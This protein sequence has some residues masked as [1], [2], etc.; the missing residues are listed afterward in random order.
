VGND[1]KGKLSPVIYIAGILG[2]LVTPWIGV[3]CFTFAALIWLVPD[4]RI[5]QFTG[6]IEDRGRG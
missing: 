5:E 3:A 2:T 6:Q 1:T 4:K